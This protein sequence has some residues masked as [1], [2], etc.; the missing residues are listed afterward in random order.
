MPHSVDA[1]GAFLARVGGELVLEAH[2]CDEKGM[3]TEAAQTKEGN[4]G[5][6]RKAAL[7]KV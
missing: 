7:L 1:V 2:G 6:V 5:M 4:P 3:A